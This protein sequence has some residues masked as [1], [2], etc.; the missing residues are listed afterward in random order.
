MRNPDTVARVRAPAL[1]RLAA[2]LLC[3]ATA[4]PAG[5][6]VID[7]D[8]RRAAVLKRCDEPLHHGRIEEARTCFRPLLRSSEP[9]IRAE[10]AWALGDLRNAND[11]FRE[12]V[13][14]QPKS[15]LPRIR[16]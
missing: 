1:L 14:A 12:A 13:A 7:Y 15:A 11:F 6:Q 9:L 3:V 16:W 5:A 8:P 2:A 4:W 10:A